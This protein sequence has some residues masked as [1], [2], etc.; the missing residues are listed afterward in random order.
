MSLHPSVHPHVPA[1]LRLDE[2]P[3]SF[4][5]GVPL[6]KIWRGT[7]NY[8]KFGH[9][10]WICI[11][12][13]CRKYF[14]ARQHS[15]GKT[16]LLLYC[17][18]LHVSQQQYKGKTLLRLHGNNGYAKAPHCLYWF[19]RRSVTVHTRN[20]ITADNHHPD[21]NHFC[22]EHEPTNVLAQYIQSQK[23]RQTRFL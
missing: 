18:Q 6:T 4:V 5:L 12:E 3:W 17:L 9:F 13:S 10:T 7:Q 2:F 21:K 15:K 19:V 11:V 22:L 1:R 8:V 23:R 20:T 16:L 14:V